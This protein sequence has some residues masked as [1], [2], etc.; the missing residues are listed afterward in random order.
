MFDNQFNLGILF[1]IFLSI[2]VGWIQQTIEFAKRPQIVSKKN[3]QGTYE[4]LKQHPMPFLAAVMFKL[5]Y[6]DQIFGKDKSCIT[7]II[8]KL[9]T[10]V[11]NQ[12]KKPCS[13]EKIKKFAMKNGIIDSNG[14]HMEWVRNNFRDYKSVDDFFTR[15]PGKLPT[16]QPNF[17]LTS[18]C[19]G[20]VVGY[21]SIKLAQRFWIKQ[22]PFS[23]NTMGLPDKFIYNFHDGNMLIFKLDVYDIHHYYSPV[24]GRIIKRIDFTEPLRHSSSVR[25]FAMQAGWEILT[26]NRRVLLLIE[27]DLLG[28]ICVLIVGGIGIDSIEMY[29][30]EGDEVRIGTDLGCFHMGGSAIVILTPE[31]YVGGAKINIRPDIACSSLCEHE[32]KINLCEHLLQE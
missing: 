9:V 1:G 16:P 6:V 2:C 12:N 17:T 23:L 14:N 4:L 7:R 19:E 8:Q 11:F 30:D 24:N 32:F 27:S 25:P 28:L 18:P 3:G 20:T 13:V 31:S 26:E 29:V 22:K 15:Q 5:L 21:E 10:F